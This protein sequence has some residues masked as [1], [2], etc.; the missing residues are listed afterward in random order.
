VFL[1]LE[2]HHDKDKELFGVLVAIHNAINEGGQGGEEMI[3]QTLGKVAGVG[4]AGDE[5]LV[6]CLPGFVICDATIQVVAI[7][8]VD[9]VTAD[10]IN[11]QVNRGL[12]VAVVAICI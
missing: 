1:L 4:M 12:F 11:F 10:F 8:V 2:N 7:V 3:G 5:V 6:V 9:V